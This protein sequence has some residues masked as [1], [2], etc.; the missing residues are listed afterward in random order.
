[1]LVFIGPLKYQVRPEILLAREP[2]CS[3]DLLVLRRRSKA[4]RRQL[5]PEL[6]TPI[7]YPAA[8]G[9]YTPMEKREGT[10]PPARQG[11]FIDEAESGQQFEQRG[12]FC[13]DKANALNSVADRSIKRQVRCWVSVADS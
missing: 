4:W 6:D 8:L 7:I 1:V 10:Q 12:F 5:V 3:Q 11:K 9:M 13:S 2:V